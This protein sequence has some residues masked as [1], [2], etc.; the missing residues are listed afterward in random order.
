[1]LRSADALRSWADDAADDEDLAGIVL[2]SADATG[3]SAL[4]ERVRDTGFTADEIARFHAVGYTDADIAAIRTHASVGI[5]D[6]QTD[7]TYA[8]SLRQVADD[9]ESQVDAVADF[10]SEMYAV[11][12]RIEAAGGGAGQAPVAS[13]TAV[14]TS[15]FAPLDVTF[16]D[17][18][19]DADNDALTASWDFGDGSTGTGSPVHHV[20]SAGIY[21]PTLTVSDGTLSDSASTTINAIAVGPNHDPTVVDDSAST[22]INTPVSLQ[23]LNNDYDVDGQPLTVSDSTT[24]SHGTV[25]CSA[26]GD[27]LYSPAL[28]YTG[29][30]AFEYDASDGVGGSATATVTITVTPGVEDNEPPVAVDDDLTVVV[31]KSATAYTLQNDSDPDFDGLSVTLKT[32]AIHGIATCPTYGYCLYTPTADYTGPDSFEYTL[33]DGRGGIDVGTVH[34][35]VEPNHDPVA[36]DD[37]LTTRE[38]APGVRN[39]DVLT[40]DS[41]VDGDPLGVT[42]ST[43]AAHGTATCGSASCSYKPVADYTGTD[44]FDYTI[45][46]GV[47][48]TAT[49]TVTVT[50]TPNQP[51]IATDDTAQTPK[52]QPLGITPLGNDSDPDLDQITMTDHTTPAHGDLDCTTSC[53][54]TPDVG[55][56]G[57]DGFDYTITDGT[58]T[59][60]G[61]VTITVT[62]PCFPARCIDNGTVLLAVNPEAHLNAYD[63]TGSPAGPGSVGLDFIPTNNDSTAPGCLCEGWGAADAGSGVTGYANIASDSGV[64]NLHLESFNSTSSTA[65][66]VVTIDDTLRVTH[67]FHPSTKT[68]NLYEVTVTIE[69][70]SGHALDDIRYRRV[71]D[72]DIEPTAFSEYVT[73]QGGNASALLFDSDNGFETANPLGSRTDYGSTGD[74]TDA[75]P[76][77][78]GALF[79]FGFGALADGASTTFNI[80]YGGAASEAEAEE[81]I[82]AVG[83]EV[84]SIG[85]P[86]TADGPT[87]GTPNTFI[88][89]FGSVGGD[90]IFSPIAVDDTLTTPAG[91]P[92]N[93]D[94]LVNDTD[95]DDDPLTV[96]TLAPTAAHGTVACTAAGICTYTPAAGYSGPDSFDYDI[97]DGNGGSDTGTVAVTVQGGNHPP[98]GTV[99]TYSGPQDVAIVV[100]ALTGVLANDTDADGDSLT[101]AKFGDPSHGS[102]TLA[103]DGSFTYTPVAG[104]VGPDAFTYKV[105]DGTATSLPIT[106]SL[107]ITHVNHAPVGVVDSYT[108]PQDANLVVAAPG[109]LTNDTDADGDSLTA[110]KFGDP[111]HG[112]VTVNANGSFTYVPNAGY[113]GPDAFTYKVSDG[114]ATSAATTVSLTITH[115]NHTPTIADVTNMTIPEM[116]LF[117]LTLAGNDSDGDTLT[118]SA[119]TKPTGLAVDPASGAL[120]WTPTEAQGPGT[121]PVTVRVTDPDGRF[122]E[123]S[124]DI[125]V[126]E[127]NRMPALA[128][129]ADVTVYPGDLVSLTASGTDPDLPANT[130]TYGLVSGPSGASV[131]STSGAFAWTAS[132]TLG[133]YAVTIGVGDG[134]GGSAQ[135]TFTI[136]VVRDTTTLTLGGDTSGQYSDRATIT[137]TLKVG[138]TGVGG[139]SVS[140]GLGA[141]TQTV[142]TNASG[143]ASATF[144][145]PGP[146]GSLA[147]SASFAGTTSRTPATASGT[148]AVG[149]EDASIVYAGDTIGLASATLH[150]SA[151]FTDSAATGYAGPGKETGSGATIGDITKARIAFEVYAAA[152]CL[153]GS[154]ITTLSAFVT[155]TG[156]AGDGVG[157]ATV[158]W[159]SS[160]EG[161][162]CVVVSLVGPTG[163]GANGFY[164]APPAEP[165]GLAVFIDTTGKVTGGGWVPLD[166]GRANFGFNAK[167]DGSK[168]KG[169]LVF[170]ERTTY[171][172]KKAMLIVKSNAL[173]AMRT[174]GTAFPITATLNGKGSYKY[175]SSVDGSTL[176]ESGNATFTATVVDTGVKGSSP[177]DSFAIRVLDK[178]G[179]VLVDL[180][181]TVLGGGNVVAHVK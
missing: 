175:I 95:P 112:S 108:G 3:L 83:A 137:A 61:H 177:G 69:N 68:P 85:E 27:C 2:T 21:A 40:N 116:V 38:N 8:D 180:A 28:D 124:F 163:T 42:S 31:N 49:A 19:T 165:A 66:S 155:D 92:G 181:R 94:V 9:L 119:P 26:G 82:N 151:T 109:V 136:H 84:F 148:F 172:G 81:A 126:T 64:H 35:T 120:T 104:Y 71:M 96:T 113:V 159:S 47:G 51:P 167:S 138:T 140:I 173:D 29:P 160:A 106:V 98:V 79:D 101:A 77:D 76:A 33:A 149:R 1:M 139:A 12:G 18:S 32:Q 171:R 143:V 111:S 158:D 176:A 114:T 39:V 57:D 17:T 53:T 80:F 54:Y 43:A 174:S 166:D 110:A 153:T 73:I 5:D 178:S 169:N 37:V 56:V 86:S 58:D 156:A 13:F 162:F 105:S 90:P 100:P 88:F 11:A 125:A 132:S 133:D 97:S 99:D 157:S 150:L 107:T 74:F 168:V 78:H 121:Y 15:G 67:D 154:P 60:V 146:A 25:T 70:I 62:P 44:A 16:T 6:I 34:V 179:V 170:I 14:P 65:I 152:S 87:L 102:V 134:A 50:V 142:T 59:D 22:A 45:S 122:A 20:Y 23:V 55:F 117:S 147:T 46:D 48:G 161:S 30:D 89:A 127:V 129:I 93:V 103:A 72:W 10:A 131:G 7:T 135:R 91:T 75:G 63:G 52:G 41:D 36:V 123:D 144:T 141:A 145:I 4:Y 115:V 24:P 164:A 128:A 130:L 118:Y